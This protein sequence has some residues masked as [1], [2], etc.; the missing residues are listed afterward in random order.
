MDIICAARAALKSFSSGTFLA[1]SL[2]RTSPV[3][4]PPDSAD[5]INAAVAFE[6][7]HGLTPEKLLDEAKAMERAFGRGGVWARNAPRPLDVDVLV[8]GR[9]RRSSAQFTVPHPRATERAFVLVPLDEI[10][11]DF[12]WP[13]GTATVNELLAELDTDEVIS[14]LA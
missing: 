6:P 11:P 2:Y 10:V 4:C 9:E 7:V 8:Y 3:D 5:F 13:G 1:S 12:V 14:R